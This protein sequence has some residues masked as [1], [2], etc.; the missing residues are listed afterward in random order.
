[1]W[2]WSQLEPERLGHETQCILMD[3]K[4]SLYLSS[5]STLEFA[6]LVQG[7]RV[8]LET[9]VADWVRRAI[10]QLSLKTVKLSHSH[11]IESYALP[12]P[13]HRDPADRMLVATARLEGLT[14][15]TAD[16]RI[17]DYPGVSTHD[18]RR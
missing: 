16:Q 11:A 13:F 1:M 10:S 8:V 7:G 4:Y 3:M 14:M 18:A 15:L 12:P 2:V 5:V 6:R 17:L 9:T